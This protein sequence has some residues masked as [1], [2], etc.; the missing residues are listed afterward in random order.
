MAGTPDDAGAWHHACPTDAIAEGQLLPKLI[1]GARLCL[2][3]TTSGYF[4]IADT[5]P[6]AGGSLSEGMIDGDE[7]VCPLHAWGFDTLSG[8]CSEDPSCNT[9]V[10]QVRVEAGNLQVRL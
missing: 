10:Y 8:A 7:V 2:G 3:R 5:C 4:A 1:R 9:L 6:H